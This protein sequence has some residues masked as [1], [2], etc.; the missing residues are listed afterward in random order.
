MR[1]SVMFAFSDLSFLC[2][3]GGA[4]DPSGAVRDVSLP[5]PAMWPN[6]AA[7]SAIL[8]FRSPVLQKESRT[9]T[10]S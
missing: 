3:V 1:F 9:V 2:Y 8:A 6:L 4:I 5:D 7:G 10:G